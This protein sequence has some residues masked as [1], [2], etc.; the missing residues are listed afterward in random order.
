ML[1]SAFCND[2]SMSLEGFEIPKIISPI[3][4]RGGHLQTLWAHYLSSPKILEKS[5][6]F[7]VETSD[8]DHLVCEEYLRASE[9][10]MVLLHGLTGDSSAD[11]MQITGREFLKQ[12]F[13]LVLMNH[14][15]AGVHQDKAKK[16][17]HSGRSDDLSSILKYLRK[18]YPDKKI[19]T[20]GY[21]MSGNIV[22]LNAAGFRSDYLPDM[23]VA[24]NA[25]IDLSLCSHALASGFNR[26][27]DLRFVHRLRAQVESRAKVEKS[28]APLISAWATIRDF[29]EIVTA[30]ISGFKSR[31]DYYDT[32]SSKNYLHQLSIPLWMITSADDPFVPLSTYEKISIPQ[33][34]K[35]SVAPS[36]GHLGYLHADESGVQRWLGLWAESFS[37]AVLRL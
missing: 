26:I 8:G 1:L 2:S 22:A 14:R 19:I 31:D 21:S 10:I 4:A 36:G 34:A 7:S 11:Y 15:G 6:V 25:P 37:Q 27:Y 20:V 29:D 24:F 16:I 17:Y 9:V 33:I 3:W 28:K 35:L 13:H 12:G 5:Q 30:P 18:K 32:C 23:A